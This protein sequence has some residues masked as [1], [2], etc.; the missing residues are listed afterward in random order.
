MQFGAGHT[1]HGQW[2][3]HLLL[4]IESELHRRSALSAWVRRGL[5]NNE[6]L[7]CTELDPHDA[8]RSVTSV[9]TDAGI[10]VCAAVAE[11]R[12]LLLPPATYYSAQTAI[13][14]VERALDEGFS[15]VRV[16]AETD[17]ALT[18]M[19]AP[20]FAALEA[21]VD[22]FSRS[23]QFSALCQYRVPA[24][25]GRL[26]SVVTLHSGGVRE[27]QLLSSPDEDT[28]RLS[29]S[30]D[31]CNAEVLA[32][33]VSTA[34]ATSTGRL[35]IRLD[36]VESMSVTACRALVTATADFRAEGGCVDLRGP[37]P[38]V[39]ELLRLLHLETL[40]TI[41]RDTASE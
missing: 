23:Q 3:G 17:V 36:D 25:Q 26:N 11:R 2:D 40:M 16:S 9:L 19:T 13:E 6:R 37:R 14:C 32:A 12:L 20:Q 27:S 31:S 34:A 33:V 8:E 21:W 35:R 29:G 41:S 1:S 30:V 22:D 39:E 28:L 15:G 7:I 5:D 4:L 38:R 10:D 24:W 18:V